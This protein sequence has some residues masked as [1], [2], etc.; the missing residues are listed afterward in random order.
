MYIPARDFGFHNRPLS[1]PAHHTRTRE[2]CT[3][4]ANLRFFGSVL[5]PLRVKYPDFRGLPLPLFLPTPI[6]L[7]C[8]V[9]TVQQSVAINILPGVF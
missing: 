3:G 2:I 7:A 4:L 9:L 8:V 6:I 5:V 1:V